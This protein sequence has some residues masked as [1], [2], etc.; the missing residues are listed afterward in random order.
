MSVNLLLC[1]M[2]LKKK[3]LVGRKNILKDAN[4]K[5]FLVKKGLCM[6][7]LGPS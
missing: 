7:N 1:F 5:V 6:L 4:M 3:E 2:L